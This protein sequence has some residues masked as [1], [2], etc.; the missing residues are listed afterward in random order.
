MTFTD[1]LVDSILILLVVRQLR[2]SR[3][4]RRAVLLPLA[5]VIGVANSYLHGVPTRGNSLLLVL[6]LGAV[7]LALGTCS[8][9]ATRV[10]ADGG[11]YP[12]VKAGAVSAVLWVLGM[13]GRMTFAI[14]ASSSGGQASLAS[15]SYHHGI[16]SANTWTAALVIMALAEVLSRVGILYLRGQRAVAAVKPHAEL[17]Q[18]A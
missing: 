3:L 15:F 14:W 11:R 16:T 13:G 17:A 1:Y 18:V 7:G 6:L 8:A 12:L 4:D 10:W 5:I 9:L 2:T